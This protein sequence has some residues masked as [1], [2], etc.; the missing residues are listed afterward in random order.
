VVFWRPRKWSG[1]RLFSTEVGTAE[2]GTGKRS[3]IA[4]SSSTDDAEISA[5]FYGGCSYGKPTNR[6]LPESTSKP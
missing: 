1:N 2:G 5:H 4:E 6:S 3:K